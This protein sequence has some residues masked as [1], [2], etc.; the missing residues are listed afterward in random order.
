MLTTLALSSLL[1]G[2]SPTSAAPPPPPPPP[3]AV[4]DAVNAVSERVAPHVPRLGERLPVQVVPLPAVV[5]GITET[6]ELALSTGLLRA[7]GSEAE[8]AMVLAY[9]HARSLPGAGAPAA[10][11]RAPSTAAQVGRAIVLGAATGAVSGAVSDALEGEDDIVRWAGIGAASAGTATWISSAWSRRGSG[12]LDRAD[13]D[14]VADGMRAVVAA[15]YD[16]KAALQAWTA[17]NSASPAGGADGSY[18]DHEANRKRRKVASK[19][20]DRSGQQAS[21]QLV[22][23]RAEYVRGVLTPLAQAEV[24]ASRARVSPAGSGASGTTGSAPAAEAPGSKPSREALGAALGQA[25]D[26]AAPGDWLT[27]D[28]SGGI[29]GWRAVVRV[30]RDGAASATTSRGGASTETLR[31]SP[32]EL[33]TLVALVDA[34]LAAPPRLAGE[35]LQQL[36]DGQVRLLTV[37]AEEG[38]RVLV[39]SDGYRL[40]PSD[41]DLI[42]ALEELV[43]KG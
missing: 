43:P 20:L 3:A 24:S 10:Q 11:S 4:V 42:R 32:A 30:T 27:Y 28:R 34:A 15:G 40:T 2:A 19:V 33:E 31:L 8:L 21:A 26:A 6:G 14:A 39:L 35:R 23:G 36:R 29:T 17:L 41:H 5:A 12:A 37:R 38:E 18:G 13:D 7:L 16:G 22:T 9:E 1:A 25:R